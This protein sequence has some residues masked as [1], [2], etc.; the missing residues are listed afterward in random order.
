MHLSWLLALLWPHDT[1]FIGLCAALATT[2]ATSNYKRHEI[3]YICVSS[4]QNKFK[5]NVCL[6]NVNFELIVH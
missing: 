4:S 1:H 2:S 6:G 5:V 3:E